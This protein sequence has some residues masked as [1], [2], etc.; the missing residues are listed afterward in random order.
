MLMTQSA[1][2]FSQFLKFQMIKKKVLYKQQNCTML[3][4]NLRRLFMSN[5]VVIKIWSEPAYEQEVFEW[6]QR[7]N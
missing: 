6:K 3:V 2:D 4:L 1:V 7:K 5:E